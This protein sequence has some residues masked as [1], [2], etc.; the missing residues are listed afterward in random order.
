MY[1][2]THTPHP[3]PLKYFR[4]MV[5]SNT[6][7]IIFLS[8]T[9]RGESLTV[10]SGKVSATAWQD[11]KVVMIMHSNSETQGVTTVLRQQSKGNREEVQCPH[12]VRSYNMHMGGVDKGDQKRGYYRCRVKSRKFYKYVF[13]FLLDVA[14]TNSYILYQGWSGS[15][16]IS[17]KK[18]RIKLAKEIIGSYCS[19]RRAGRG[20]SLIKPLPFSHFPMKLSSSPSERKRGRCT[21]CEHHKKKRTDTQWYC[22]ECGKWLCH[23]GTELDCF[24]LWHKTF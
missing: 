14:I 2:V 24:L 1:L 12:A 21:Y 20:G 3:F 11:K 10:Q 19:R 7:T 16:K 6:Q 18:Y 13:Y 15:T 22:H 8:L 5:L 4:V 9:F 23:T 17:I